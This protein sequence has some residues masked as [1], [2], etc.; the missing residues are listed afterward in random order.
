MC[1]VTQSAVSVS[2]S[3]VHDLSSAIAWPLSDQLSQWQCLLRTISLQPY[4]KIM[5]KC[6]FC[7]YASKKARV[8]F[9]HYQMNCFSVEVTFSP[10]M[11]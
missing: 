4:L 10:Y 1:K 9:N 5:W 7:F 11:N 2:W 6:Y 3:P 8:W